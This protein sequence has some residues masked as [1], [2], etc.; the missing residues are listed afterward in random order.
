[1]LHP[2]QCGMSTDAQLTYIPHPLH[3]GSQ[4]LSVLETLNSSSHSIHTVPLSIVGDRELARELTARF[5][6]KTPL[7]P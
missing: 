4:K 5:L 2:G 6:I 7:Y 3:L 1:M